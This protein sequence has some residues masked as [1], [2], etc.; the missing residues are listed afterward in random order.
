MIVSAAVLVRSRIIEYV[1]KPLWQPGQAR[2]PLLIPVPSLQGPP[3][4][5]PQWIV[6]ATSERALTSSM[7]SISPFSGHWPGPSIQNAGQ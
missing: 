2:R 3:G 6:P 7:M 5:V 1:W 4:E